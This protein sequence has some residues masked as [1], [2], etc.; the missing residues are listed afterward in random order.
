MICS[1]HRVSA[2]VTHLSIARDHC[3]M[4]KHPATLSEPQSGKSCIV[5]NL[6]QMKHHAIGFNELSMINKNRFNFCI[7]ANVTFEDLAGMYLTG[8][9][10]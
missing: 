4:G 8:I 7:Y 6:R 10:L 3:D 9:I 2:H 1:N 5:S